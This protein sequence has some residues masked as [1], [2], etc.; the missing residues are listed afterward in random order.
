MKK[1]RWKD[2]Y[3]SDYTRLIFNFRNR[4][5]SAPHHGIL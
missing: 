5:T 2:E 3:G 4:G 1:V